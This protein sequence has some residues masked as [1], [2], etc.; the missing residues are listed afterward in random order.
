MVREGLDVEPASPILREALALSLVRQGKKPAAFR[1]FEQAARGVAAT[2]R[3]IYLYALALDDANRRPEALRV[4]ADGAKRHPDRD[5]LLTLALWQ[6]EVG[7]AEA[8]REALVAWQQINP[9][10]PALPRSPSLE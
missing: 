6:S 5:L 10:D 8:A 7:N 1:E 2:A 3:Q 9:D 4:L